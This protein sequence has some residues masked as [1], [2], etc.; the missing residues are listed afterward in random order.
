MGYR[1]GQ[2][3][4]EDFLL[5]KASVEETKRGKK[6]IK[7]S[8][9]DH[10]GTEIEQCKRWDCSEIPK[11]PVLHIVGKVDEF[12][13]NQHIIADK[14]EC[15]KRSVGEFSP[16]APWKLD[17]KALLKEFDEGLGSILNVNLR[18]WTKDFVFY[19]E[20]HGFPKPCDSSGVD[21]ENAPAG[22]V[23]HHAYQHGWLEHVLE[24]A[25]ICEKLSNIYGEAG[26]ISEKE[27]DLLMS[28]AFIHDVGKLF[29]FKCTNGVYE[30][31]DLCKAYGW[32]SNAEQIIGSNMLLLYCTKEEFPP[33]EMNVFYAL[34]NMIISHHG[35]QF[36]I[37][38][39]SYIISRLLHFADHIS[40]DAN[41][42][43]RNLYDKNEVDRDKVRESYM[44]IS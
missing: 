2:L 38:N 42:M 13:G 32:H 43:H 28:G 6:Y 41:R 36:S 21:I 34:N 1:T 25:A 29:Q 37:G 8:V 15:G 3:I 39:S 16:K 4:N 9:R 12:A 7:F 31:T 22:I 14:W 44:R 23:I 27:C 19:W 10:G 30:Y 17:G 18:K 26:F 5:L 33:G 24:V 35:N 40:A 20:K 11:W